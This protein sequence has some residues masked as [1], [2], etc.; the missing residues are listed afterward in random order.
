LLKE[1]AVPSS[2]SGRTVAEFQ[3]ATDVWGALDQWAQEFKFVLRAQDEAS[4]L[5]QKG[6]NILIPPLMV[7]MTRTEAAYHL[8]VWVRNPMINRVL[9]FGL[10]PS[11]MVI[12]KGG[13]I[14]FVPRD[15]AR[16]E[17]NVL[18]ERLGVP[19]IE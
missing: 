3:T 10:L 5:Y 15:K 12:N 13:F 18:L 9:S 14:G 8:E 2:I 16:K 11:E 19:L 4:R 1:A 17:V 6:E 7:Q